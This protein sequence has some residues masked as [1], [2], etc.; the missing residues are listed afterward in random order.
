MVSARC[1]SQFLDFSLLQK[2]SF[3]VLHL[4]LGNQVAGI[5]ENDFFFDCLLESGFDFAKIA[6]S[7]VLRDFGHQVGF[8]RLKPIVGNG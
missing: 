8:E 5:A 1:L 3:G 2:R 6:V 4:Y 7:R